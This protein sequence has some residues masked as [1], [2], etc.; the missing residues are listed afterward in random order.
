MICERWLEME[1]TSDNYINLEE[2]ATYLGI[3][4]VTLRN[5]I[6]K[7]DSGLPAHRIGKQWKF[8]K[9]ELD[10]WINSGKSAME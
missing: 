3:R 10:E 6:K 8:K 1:K 7:E 2:T 5:W 4:P 9:S